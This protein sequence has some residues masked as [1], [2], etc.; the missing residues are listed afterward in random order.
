MTRRRKK[1]PF[2]REI[3]GQERALRLLARAAASRRLPH[4]LLFAGPRGVGKRSAALAF[5]RFL[6]CRAPADGDGC[7]RCPACR[8]FASHTHPDLTIVVPETATIK[9]EQIRGLQRTLAFPPLEGGLRVTLVLRAQTMA[10]AAANALLKTLEEPPPGNLLILTAEE[11]AP[12]LPTILSRCQVIP[13][14]ELDDALVRELT[15][16]DGDDEEESGE[17]ATEPGPALTWLAA[18][19]AGL[20]E[21]LAR[22][23]MPA[24]LDEVIRAVCEPA[25]AARMI[26]LAG[27]CAKLKDELP[28]FLQGLY[29]WT[30]DMARH[31][32]GLGERAAARREETPAPARRLDAKTAAD[33]LAAINRA[34]ALLARN[35]NRQAVCELLFIRLAG[36]MSG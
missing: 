26:A 2:L 10:A 13:F 19:S 17:E 18:G 4:A 12:L 34:R 25:G 35:C 7:G 32:C 23:R 3:R 9:I 21:R 28:L 36:R 24:L 5:A 27:E 11:D 16:S 29:A 31:A 1:I 30:A 15:K 22:G 14:S 33:L 6:L 8:K 20:A